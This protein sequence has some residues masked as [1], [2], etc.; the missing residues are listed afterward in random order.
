MRI[1]ARSLLVLGLLG[2]PALGSAAPVGASVEH[3]GDRKASR[4]CRAVERFDIDEVGDPTTAK[5][6]AQTA[7][8]LRKLARA[9]RGKTRAALREII[10][11]YDEVV[12]GGD[13]GD[14]F[15]TADFASAAARLAFE[16]G[17]CYFSKL[18]DIDLPDVTLPDLG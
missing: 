10:T 14:A 11:A 8:E 3:L 12:D 18:P 13:A 7:K 5:G 9:A 17:K 2:V 1:A 6:A 16:V 4:F 15:A